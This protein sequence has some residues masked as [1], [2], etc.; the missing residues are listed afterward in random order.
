MGGA[1]RI[2]LVNGNTT[3]AVTEKLAAGARRLWAEARITALT[4]AF[5]PPYIATPADVA[6]AGHA[7][8]AAVAAAFPADHAPAHDAVVIGCFGEPG[9]HAARQLAPVPVTGMA[10]AAVLAALQLGGRYGIVTL[11][12]HWPGMLRELLRLYGLD[13]RLA[14]IARVEGEALVLA[15][16]PAA[17][18]AAVERAA[19][20][21]LDRE[22]PDVLILGGAALVGIAELIRE[23]VPVPLVDALA[24]ALGQ[25]EA[26]LRLRPPQRLD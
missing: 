4:P 8:A 11:G 26:L 17:A 9:L 2:L 5:G 20:Q 13:A 3:P 7:V 6:I 12:A 1:A 25:V 22:R 15:A 18:A 24:A 19:G 23:R 21:L 14:G 10:E 16:D